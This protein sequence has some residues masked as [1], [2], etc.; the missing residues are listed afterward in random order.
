LVPFDDKEIVALPF[1]DD[2]TQFLLSK[3]GI[4]G[5]DFIFQR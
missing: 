4:S 2:P 5:E 1:Q 3:E